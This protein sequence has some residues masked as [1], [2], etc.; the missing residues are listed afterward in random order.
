MN[1]RID[2]RLR[3]IKPQPSSPVSFNHLDLS[4]LNVPLP[5]LFIYKNCNPANPFMP[6]E[7][8]LNG[9]QRVVD[10]H[11][12][13]YDRLSYGNIGFPEIQPPTKGVHVYV[14]DVAYSFAS[15]DS[16]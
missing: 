13:L 9:L 11:L 16:S 6:N 1:N 14:N 7:V 15:F 10:A 3:P 12:I 8:L 5:C 2:Y 4:Q